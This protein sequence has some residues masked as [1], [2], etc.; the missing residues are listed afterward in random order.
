VSTTDSYNVIP[1]HI[2]QSD[3]HKKAKAFLENF[4]AKEGVD[5]GWAIDHAKSL[6]SETN[7]HFASL[8]DK[9]DSII[10]YL[11]GGIGLFSLGVLAKADASNT[12]LILWALP[13]IF[14]A[15]LSVFFAAWVRKP[16]S[17]PRM[18]SI[19]A[20]VSCAEEESGADFLG[21][22]HYACESQLMAN[23]SKAKNLER[24]TLCYCLSLALLALPLLAAVYFYYHPC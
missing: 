18:P 9:A 14:L 6:W 23:E 24:A 13:A 7:K 5:Y 1:A 19:E 16:N 17:V 4:R 10:K 21:Q 2:E 3:R 22:W 8:D 15:V 20:A 11:G 12:Y